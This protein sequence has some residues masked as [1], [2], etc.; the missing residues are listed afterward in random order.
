VVQKA[1]GSKRLILILG[2]EQNVL[3]YYLCK[4]CLHCVGV[5]LISCTLTHKKIT[6]LGKYVLIFFRP[7]INVAKYPD[8]ETDRQTVSVAPYQPCLQQAMQEIRDPHIFE[9]NE[10]PLKI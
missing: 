4:D 10:N 5:S 2:T 7:I 9:R 6:R 8:A 1:L 3:V